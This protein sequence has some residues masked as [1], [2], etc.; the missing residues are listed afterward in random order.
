MSLKD[1]YS[2]LISYATSAGVQNLSV[3]EQNNVLYIKGM[4]KEPVKDQL[5]NLY[6]QADPDMRSADLVLDIDVVKGGEDMYEIRKGDNLSKIADK[7]PGMT[8][9][10]IYEAN[11]DTLDNPDKIYPGQKIRIPL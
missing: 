8:W 10:K 9:Q 1:K 6:Q 3:Q 4:A 5:W 2:K 11:K 7:Y